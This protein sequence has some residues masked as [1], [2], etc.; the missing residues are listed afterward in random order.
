MKTGNVG[1]PATIRVSPS[2]VQEGD[3]LLSRGWGRLSSVICLLDGGAYSH[4]GICV[5]FDQD[6]MPLIVEATQK[7]VVAN[8][9]E[10]DQAVQRYI[11]LYRFKPDPKK[12]LPPLNW[13]LTPVINKANQYLAIGTQ[14][15]YSQLLL[16]GILVMVRKAPAGELGQAKI[17]YWLAKFVEYFKAL[18]T[19]NK[20]EVTCSELIYRCFYEAKTTPPGKYG[21]TIRG[22]IGPGGH[23]IKA[24]SVGSIPAHMKLDPE[25]AKVFKEAATVL[26]KIKPNFNP[27][28]KQ[29]TGR[30]S[31]IGIMAAN[32]NVCADMVTPYDLQKSPNLVKVGEFKRKTVTS[33]ANHVITCFFKIPSCI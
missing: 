1:N 20:E 31:T 16:M 11:D 6:K 30:R 21:L 26:R 8:R 13:P 2:N 15:A 28:I 24:F 23:L 29:I 12:T 27:S 14:Y 19:S 32:P 33:W 22:T 7:G 9:L 18:I 3:V 17:R 25:T 4:S 10:D 5:G